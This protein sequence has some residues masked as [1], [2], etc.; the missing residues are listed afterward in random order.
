MV[1]V[2]GLFYKVNLG[3]A[4]FP[5]LDGLIHTRV[6]TNQPLSTVHVIL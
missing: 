4:K 2:F 6:L 3:T 5:C 1:S